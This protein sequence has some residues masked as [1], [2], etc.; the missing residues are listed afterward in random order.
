MDIDEAMIRDL[1]RLISADLDV[2][3]L[4]IEEFATALG[5][6]AAMAVDVLEVYGF[7]AEFRLA[8]DGGALPFDEEEDAF[9]PC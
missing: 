1:Y 2:E 6:S 4:L 3:E 8:R 7:M 9:C 5:I